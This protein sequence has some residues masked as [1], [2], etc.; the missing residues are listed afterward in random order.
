MIFEL[1][2][3]LQVKLLRA[4]QNREIERVG[5]IQKL[6]INTRIIAATNKSLKSLVD[7]KK[8]RLDLYY[9]L[10][11]FPIEVPSL[12]DRKEDIIPL[13]QHFLKKYA[14]EFSLPEVALTGDAEQYLLNQYWEGNIRELENLVQRSLIFSQGQTITSAILESKPGQC[15]QPLLLTK[16]SSS[17]SPSIASDLTIEP[18]EE[19]E[20]KAIQHVLTLKNGNMLQAAKSLGISRTTLYKKIEKYK[21]ET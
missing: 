3:D 1:P 2:L 13:T 11:V 8:F 15:D 4:I 17:K 14:K 7:N 16:E 20:K 10:N 21:L 6:K 18:L 5:G 9:R 19:T 12:R